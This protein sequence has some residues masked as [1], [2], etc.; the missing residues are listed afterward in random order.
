MEANET[1]NQY[2]TN[3]RQAAPILKEY[4]F[5]ALM[6]EFKVLAGDLMER[7]SATNGPKITEIINRYL[8]R[9]KKVTEAIPEQAELI[10]LIN[11]EIKE[12]LLDINK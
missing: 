2:V 11:S 8:G 1:N 10:Y 4:D 3:D 12:T 7:N 5:D 9:G 6:N